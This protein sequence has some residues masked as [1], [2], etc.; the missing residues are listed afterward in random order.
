MS[1]ENEELS[2]LSESMDDFS[3]LSDD[4]DESSG[5]TIDPLGTS[6]TLPNDKQTSNE[7]DVQLAESQALSD[8]SWSSLSDDDSVCLKRARSTN[9]LNIR[10]RE[11][12]SAR[13]AAVAAAAARSPARWRLSCG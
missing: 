13:R 4:L 5:V 2:C 11:L 10:R 6:E 3:A 9:P 8:M 7:D 1:G 12:R